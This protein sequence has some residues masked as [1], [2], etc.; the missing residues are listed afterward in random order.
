MRERAKIAHIEET[1]AIPV[2]GFAAG[3]LDRARGAESLQ[4]RSKGVIEPRRS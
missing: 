4:T 2:L 3:L 1:W